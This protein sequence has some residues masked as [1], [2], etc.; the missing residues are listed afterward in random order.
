[1]HQIQINMAEANETPQWEDCDYGSFATN[2]EALKHIEW[3]L[4]EYGD[5]IEYRIV[6]V[7]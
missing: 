4:G 1:M 6:E 2:A 7:K 5:T 3:S